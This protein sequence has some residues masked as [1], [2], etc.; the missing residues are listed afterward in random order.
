MGGGRPAVVA[1]DDVG[2]GIVAVGGVGIVAVGG[3]VVAGVG[4]TGGCV[5][6]LSDNRETMLQV[7]CCCQNTERHV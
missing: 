4:F 1:V 2:I 7:F 6:P 3:V 5:P